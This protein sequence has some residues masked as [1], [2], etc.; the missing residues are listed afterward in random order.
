MPNGKLWR[1]KVIGTYKDTLKMA[2]PVSKLH[3]HDPRKSQPRF[4]MLTENAIYSID[5]KS[6]LIRDKIMLLDIRAI[7]LSCLRDGLFVLH[8]KSQID[9]IFR[10]DELAIDFNTMLIRQCKAIGCEIKV[11]VSNSILF[12]VDNNPTRI[13]FEISPTPANQFMTKST[14][15]YLVSIL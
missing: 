15:G 9:F 8:G 3:L 4:L 7:S 11:N 1:S 13:S 10:S 14:G 2:I 12:H 6:W 5:Q